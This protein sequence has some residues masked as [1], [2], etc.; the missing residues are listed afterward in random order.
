MNDNL[1]YIL[2]YFKAILMQLIKPFSYYLNELAIYMV[3]CHFQQ[4]LS[5]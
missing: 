1:F 4:L 2:F 3:I 5:H